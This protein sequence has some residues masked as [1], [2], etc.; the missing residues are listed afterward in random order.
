MNPLIAQQ[1]AL[2]KALVSHEERVKIGKCNMRIDPNKPQKEAT[3]QVILDTVPLSPCYNAFTIIADVPEIYMHHSP[4]FPRLHN[5]EFV[6]PPSHDEM[7]TLIKSLGYKG[8]LESITDLFTDHMYQP[9]RTFPV[10]INRCLSGKTI[11]AATPKKARKWTKASTKPKTKSSFTADDN[12]ISGDTEDVPANKPTRRRRQTGVAIRDTRK[13]M[14]ASLSDL[15]SH[16]QTGGSSEGVVPDVYK[17][18]FM[19][20]DLQEDWGSKEDDV[21]LTSEDER[22][23]SEKKTTESGKN[24]DDMSI[25]LDEFDNKEAKHVDDE[26]QRDEYVHDDEYM[27][28]DDEYVHEEDEYVHEEVE[29]TEE[30][31]GDEEQ[32]DNA[33]ARGDQAKDASTQDNQASAPISVTQKEKPDLPPTSS[34]L[35]VSS[36]FVP[37]VQS[38]SLLSVPVSVIPKPTVLTPIPENVTE[39][40]ATTIPPLTPIPMSITSTIKQST[41]I[42]TPTT[43]TEAQ[44]FTTAFPGDEALFVVLLRKH[45]IDTQQQE[46]WKSV[47]KIRKIK[48]EHATKQQL[49]K[50]STKTF[51]QAARAEFDRK[52]IDDTEKT[53]TIKTPTQKKRRH[54]DKDQDPPAGPDQRLKKMKTSK[55]ETVFEAADTD[56]HVNQGDDMEKPPLTF[57]DLMSTPIDFSTFAMNHLKIR[58]ERCPY[59]L[60]EPLP[61]YESRGRLMVPDNF[62]FNNDLEYIKGGS[63]DKKY[64]AST[65]KTKAAKYELEGIEDMVPK[66]LSP[67]KFMEG[68]FPRLHLNDIED[69]LLLVV[70]KKLFNLEGDV[71]DDLA[72]ALHKLKRKRLM[73]TDKLYKFSDG[74][75]NLIHNT[76][77]QKLLNFW[78]GFNKAMERRKWT[79]TDQ[80]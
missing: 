29:K 17:A 32:V 77:Q 53:K 2:D 80:K 31:K 56:M 44:T 33:L 14:K 72:V 43:T 63:T 71:I 28:E 30:A 23:E 67:I 78:L 4:D 69:M 62:F 68:D 18:V 40:L 15:R 57:D 76:L 26:T 37:N 5:Q 46:P 27:H 7:V 9:W 51:D 1:A 73:R 42:P 3:Y 61:L 47:T 45:P 34:S 48:M 10:I 13:V 6:E 55:D 58:G 60:S 19:T 22:T 24:D 25:D 35:S 39:A 70:Q 11:G 41:P 65:T 50:H 16:H 66:L 52:E 38:S 54:D 49:L 79:V 20:Q 64:M 75:I 12:I 36:G 59:A 74:T 21:I 8:A